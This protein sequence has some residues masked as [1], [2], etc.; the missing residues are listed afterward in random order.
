[1]L[2]GTAARSSELLDQ[3]AQAHLA[4]FVSSRRVSTGGYRGRAASADTY[5]TAFALQSLRALCFTSDDATVDWLHSI[6]ESPGLDL[7][8]T[9]SLVV[10]LSIASPM[11]A[12]DERGA[13][14]LSIEAFRTADG[15][16]ANDRGL[17]RT[18]AY[19]AF[20]AVT[21]LDALGSKIC[22]P[23]EILRA[24]RALSTGDGGFAN[25]MST[26]PALTTSTA[27]A[28]VLN[29][30][31][32]GK[33]PPG[34]LQWLLARL[35]STGGFAAWQEAPGPDL[36]STATA[37][38]ALRVAGADLRPVAARLAAFVETHWHESGGFF[39]STADMTPDCEYAFY[40]LLA[41]GSLVENGGVA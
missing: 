14:A 5:Y 3:T 10:A 31:F 18:T 35:T 24:I 29:V 17:K 23:D 33:P 39:G 13:L 41:L 28:C 27:A 2:V 37:A 21:A 8:H 32:A 36:L 19:D 1:M 4:S 30:R 38:F 12:R 9:A 16:Y 6:R 34:S 15:G 20:L 26:T 11:I 7:V 25:D 22:R 40:G